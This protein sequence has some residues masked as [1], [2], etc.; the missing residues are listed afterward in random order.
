[1]EVRPARVNEKDALARLFVRAR[2]GMTYVPPVPEEHVGLIADDLF[3][4]NEDVWLAEENGHL[5]GFFAIRRSRTNDWETLERLYVEPNEQGRGIGTALLDKAKAL[6]R[7]GLY[8]WVFQKNTG[9]IRFYERHGFRLVKLTDG[10]DN[11]EREPDA[12]YAWIPSPGPGR[13]ASG[14][15][16]SARSRAA[17]SRSCPRRSP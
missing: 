4:R 12:L 2:N 17:G 8:L 6:R 16:S 11:M 3:T 1:V 7:E 9:A 5:L 13:A 14:R 15:G 10:E